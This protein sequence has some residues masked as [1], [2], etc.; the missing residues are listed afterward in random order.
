MNHTWQIKIFISA[1]MLAGAATAGYAA[2]MNHALHLS[3]AVAVLVFAAVTS[4][5]K[6]KLP[7]INGSMSVNLPFLLTA[8]I[9]LSATEA[10]A[11]RAYPLRFSAGREII[12]NSTVS[13]WHS[14]SA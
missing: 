2:L 14:T 6:V 12:R 10:I 8:V 13:R 4:R 7:G 3:Y 5:M 9:N 1:M 11:S